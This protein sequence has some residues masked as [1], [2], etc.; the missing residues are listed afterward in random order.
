MLT[1][2]LPIINIPCVDVYLSGRDLEADKDHSLLNATRT[3]KGSLVHVRPINIASGHWVIRYQEKAE[4]FNHYTAIVFQ[5]HNIQS[6]ID[7]IPD[8]QNIQ[9]P[10]CQ[11][12]N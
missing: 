10:T 8:I 3:L 7:P 12:S 1:G 9:G 6:D 2:Q 11:Q 4:I 5:P